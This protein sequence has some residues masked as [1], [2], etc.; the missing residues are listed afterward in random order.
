MLKKVVVNHPPNPGAPRRT[1]SQARP[2]TKKI[3]EAYPLGYVEDFSEA[4]TKLEAFFSILSHKCGQRRIHD[5]MADQPFQ[6]GLHR[7]FGKGSVIEAGFDLELSVDSDN[8][9]NRRRILG[10]GQHHLRLK[11]TERGVQKAVWSDR[12]L[13][14]REIIKRT[15]NG[16]AIGQSG[17]RFDPLEFCQRGF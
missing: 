7:L 10:V 5:W 16:A 2:Q 6:P 15:V 14:F 11:F 8:T 3:P 12:V 1:L 9:D 4:R 17:A 13:H